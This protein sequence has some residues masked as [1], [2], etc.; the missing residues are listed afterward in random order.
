MPIKA[1]CESCQTGFKAKDALA[2]KRVRCPKCKKPLT[3]PTAAGVG[4][5]AAVKPRSKPAPTGGVA[6][7]NPNPMMGLLDEAD[8]QGVTR[9]PTCENC[10]AEL[11]PGAVLCIDC[12]FNMETGKR[13]ASDIDNDFVSTSEMTAAERMMAKAEKDIEETPVTA[14]G[15]DF[16]DGADSLVIAGVAGGILLLLVGV[17]LV[18]IFGMEQISQWFNSGAIS[19]FAAITM[20][21][22]CGT[23]ITIVAFKQQ[24]HSHAMACIFTGFLYAVVYGFTQG[25]DLLIPT[26]ILLFSIVIA[27]ASGTYVGYNGLGPVSPN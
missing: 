17:G 23:W 7:S 8:V 2:G 18:I 24:R 11:M 15:Q 26:V 5:A 13:V 27:A 22:L 1:R 14:E 19:M 20:V 25:K 4:T 10:A 16:G 21:V 9:G 3:I 6:R 12:G